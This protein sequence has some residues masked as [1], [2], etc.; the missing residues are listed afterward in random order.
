M[1][2]FREEP[3]AP[4]QSVFFFFFLLQYKVAT[5]GR[6]WP[7]KNVD[8]ELVYQRSYSYSTGIVWVR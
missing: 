4:C 7:K 1:E 3:P 8:P 6:I 2:I 5:A